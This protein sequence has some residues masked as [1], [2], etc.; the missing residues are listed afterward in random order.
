M[1]YLI[2]RLKTIFTNTLAKEGTSSLTLKV[3]VVEYPGN[4]GI[5]QDLLRDAVEVA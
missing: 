4:G 2:E 5:V 3:R 1:T